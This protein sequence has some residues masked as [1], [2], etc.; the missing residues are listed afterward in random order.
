[1]NKLLKALENKVNNPVNSMDFKTVNFIG[2]THDWGI[3][4][5]EKGKRRLTIS[6]FVNIEYCCLKGK[7]LE[8][9]S[10]E[11]REKYLMD[12]IST[13]LA[14][15]IKYVAPD[16]ESL[17]KLFSREF[18]WIYQ[19]NERL[20]RFNYIFPLLDKKINE[21]VEGINIKK[22]MEDNEEELSNML[23]IHPRIIFLESLNKND[24]FEMYKNK[25]ITEEQFKTVLNHIPEVEEDLSTKLYPFSGNS[26]D[27]ERPR[28]TCSRTGNLFSCESCRVAAE[29]EE[30]YG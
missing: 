24:A 20:R 16:S 4:F 10:L 26:P 13:Q 5:V 18:H 28:R 15:L 19:T 29:W 3:G 1:M 7:E 8:N 12:S 25:Q 23:P 22:Y 2:P 27:P 30:A 11:E 6:H 14:V 9:H 17:K 21:M